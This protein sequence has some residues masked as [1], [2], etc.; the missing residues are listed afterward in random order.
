MTAAARKRELETGRAEWL[1]KRSGLTY[2]QILLIEN[3]DFEHI[4][5][6]S[7]VRS[8][9]ADW[10]ERYQRVLDAYIEMLELRLALAQA[11]ELADKAQAGRQEYMD[12][13]A[14]AA[15]V[16]AVEHREHI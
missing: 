11:L 4:S 13:Y 5:D 16:W 8:L 6:W 1:A 3:F 7:L 12:K 14:K 15:E 10:E 2:T 9:P